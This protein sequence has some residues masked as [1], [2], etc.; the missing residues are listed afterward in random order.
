MTTLLHICLLRRTSPA[1]RATSSTVWCICLQRNRSLTA[2]WAWDTLPDRGCRSRAACARRLLVRFS[3]DTRTYHSHLFS[4]VGAGGKEIYYNSALSSLVST[5]NESV[6]TS[7][8]DIVTAHELGAQVLFQWALRSVC[9]S[10]GHNWGS[11]HDDTTSECSPSASK[12]GK[13]IMHTYSITGFEPNNKK[14][15]PCSV[16]AIRAVLESKS[17][18]C[19]DS[20]RCLHCKWE[21]YFL[22]QKYKKPSVATDAPNKIRLTAFGKNATPVYSH[23]TT[24]AAAHRSAR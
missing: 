22:V 3:F 13:Y 19:F 2:S 5:V 14:F 4:A 20:E 24:I 10:A 16:R 9:T 12:G 11:S 7:E 1:I 17:Q 18:L 21:S 6:I 15:S 23:R 8:A